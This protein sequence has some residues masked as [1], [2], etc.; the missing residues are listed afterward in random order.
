MTKHSPIMEA[1]PTSSPELTDPASNGHYVHTNRI[2]ALEDAPIKLNIGG[3]LP[4]VGGD[5]P[6][7]DG[8]INIDARLGHDL[9]KLDYPDNSVDEIYASHVLEHIE[10][11]RRDAALA[12]WFRVLKPAGRVR[13]AVP[14]LR[15]WAKLLLDRRYDLPLEGILYGGQTYPEN[16]HK[17]GYDEDSLAYTLDKA[18]FVGVDKFAPFH[19]DCSQV[20]WSLNMEAYKPP[21]TMMGDNLPRKVIACMSAPRLLFLDQVNSC[22]NVIRPLGI[23]I[24]IHTG[25]N[26][27]QCLER[28]FTAACEGGY[29]WIVALDYDTV[30]TDAQFIRMLTLFDAYGDKWDA[31][32]PLQIKRENRSAL[33][34][35]EKD[36]PVTPE[37]MAHPIFRAD[38]AHF[39]C[40]FIKTEILKK[41]PRPWFHHVPN[42][43]GKWE[44]GRVDDDINFWK[45]FRAA[46]GR[47]GVTSRLCVGHMQLM[48]SWLGEGY[49]PVHQYV[50]DYRKDGPPLG[51]GHKENTGLVGAKGAG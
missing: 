31:L 38:S 20:P 17:S 6:P 51:T 50:S 4:G 44:D 21:Q 25:S 30:F 46:G 42:A 47:L 43:E 8:F 16:Y 10:H 33:F 7:I 27:G 12:E 36:D 40:T 13:I 23:P 24:S 11:V 26:W 39:G 28:C 22:E 19:P 15:A 3:G 2:A 1:F 48:V 49:E 34:W 37:E 18:G 45:G 41:M 9:F 32:A 35:R 29:E 14:D 5:P